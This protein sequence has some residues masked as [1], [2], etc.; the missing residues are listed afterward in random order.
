[1]L[2]NHLSDSFDDFDGEGWDGWGLKLSHKT[3]RHHKKHNRKRDVELKS[4][5]K[6]HKKFRNSCE[7]IRKMKRGVST[8]DVLVTN[9]D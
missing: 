3:P 4:T 9:R 7:M 1:M 8:K 6:T 2:N 5:H